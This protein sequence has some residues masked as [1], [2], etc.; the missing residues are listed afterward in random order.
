MLRLLPPVLLPPLPAL[1]RAMLGAAG[2]VCSGAAMGT[3][4][5]LLLGLVPG[6][7]AAG[8]G[9]GTGAGRGAEAVK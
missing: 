8:G 5:V 3:G 9:A 2:T 6:A 1:L 7:A 4:A